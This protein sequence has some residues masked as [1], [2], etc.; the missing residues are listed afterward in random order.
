MTIGA[1]AI[2]GPRQHGGGASRGA[3]AVIV[4]GKG[5]I[6]RAAA[7]RTVP[8]RARL[9]KALAPPTRALLLEIGRVAAAQGARAFAVGG[10]VRDAWRGDVVDGDL[11]VVV[12]GD[13]P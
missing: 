3:P 4:A 11:D 10:L 13:G 1:G 6:A 7:V 2:P 9:E 5:V 8:V 12:E